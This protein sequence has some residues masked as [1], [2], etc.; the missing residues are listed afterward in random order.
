MQ[1]SVVHVREVLLLCGKKNRPGSCIHIN[2]MLFIFVEFAVKKT[3][4]TPVVFNYWIS[5]DILSDSNQHL[6]AKCNPLAF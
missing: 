1:F 6:A 5:R 3:D 2:A 4:Q